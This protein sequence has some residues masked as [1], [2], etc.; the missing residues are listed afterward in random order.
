MRTWVYNRIK[1]LPGIPN[2]YGV[3]AAMRVISSGA[4]SSPEKPFLLVQFGVEQ[5]P[6][7]ATAEMRVA[8]IPFTVWVHDKPGS[9]IHIDDAAVALKKGLPTPD[10]QKV[11]N[12]S[13]Y[14]LRWVETG[15]D[16]Y[17]DH[18]MT[19]T[20]PVRFTMMTRSAG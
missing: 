11:G 16:T 3:G 20:R 15:E 17:D 14:E 1:G 8:W 4:A 18:F 9:M 12:M 19:N 7:E 6:L 10:G 13:L 5:P 2:E